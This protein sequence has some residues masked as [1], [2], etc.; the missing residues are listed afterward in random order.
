MS[1]SQVAACPIASIEDLTKDITQPIRET[2]STPFVSVKK[3]EKQLTFDNDMITRISTVQFNAG[4]SSSSTDLDKL[5][6]FYNEHNDEETL[7]QWMNI[8]EEQKLANSIAAAT[9]SLARYRNSKFFILKN[10]SNQVLI[11]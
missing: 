6:N 5:I 1:L 2:Q 11:F 4:C 7:A 9:N 8:Y 10:K 3:M